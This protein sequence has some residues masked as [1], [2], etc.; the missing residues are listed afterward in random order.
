LQPDWFH[1]IADL[2]FATARFGSE[3]LLPYK[4]MRGVDGTSPAS[5][6]RRGRHV[7]G[8]G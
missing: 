6:L 8:A 2:I 7:C 4:V 1:L 3:C 5:E